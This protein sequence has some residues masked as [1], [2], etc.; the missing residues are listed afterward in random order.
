MDNE[1]NETENSMRSLGRLAA[2]LKEQVS[3]AA[4]SF[5]DCLSLN[6]GVMLLISKTREAVSE[7]RDLDSILTEISQTS[8]MT[9]RQLK[10]LGMD[11]YDT[12]SKYGRTAGE[13]LRA[14]QE[15]ERLGFSGKKGAAMAEQSLLAQSA[16]GMD[17]ELASSYILA[18]NAAYQLNG[19]AEKL[20]AIL[21]G[22]NSITSRNSIAMADM[23][24][25]MTEAGTT[26]S[27]YRVSI[28]E[29]SAMIGTLGTVTEL[30][31]S[32]VGNA[33]KAILDNLQN[34]S[35]DKIT[36]TLNAANISMTK[37]VNGAEKLRSPIDILR[38][39][40]AAFSRLDENAPLRT[41]ILTNIGQDAHAN[42]LGALLENMDMFDRMLVDY[43]QG[44]G[45]ALAASSEN[46]ENLSGSL[47]RLSNSWTE[48]VNSFA[49][50]DT[51]KTGV[52][53]L[54]SLVQGAVKL[55]DVL[56]PLEMIGVGAGLNASFKKG[57]GL[58][59][60]INIINNS[61]FLATVEFNSD[62]YD[63]CIL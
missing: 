20:N 41:E 62:V 14:V 44:A 1:L 13:Y 52:N 25:A 24:A 6:S 43:S 4:Q 36:D 48:L 23:A 28:E 32:E 35:S 29:L 19:E 40:A 21:D 8:S 18:T 38:D 45:S 63:F 33:V 54:N 47:N 3:Q 56:T 16:G 50:S 15:M 12:A 5:S 39:L 11:A 31:G 59:R 7:I 51:L 9:S 27:G 57:G 22:Q 55:T 26:A 37:M 17:G 49:A 46:A 10:Q 53:V 42:H 61:P 2:S 30:N 60:L 34:V 58:I